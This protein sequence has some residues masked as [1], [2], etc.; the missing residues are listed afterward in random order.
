M[1]LNLLYIRSNYYKIFVASEIEETIKFKNVPEDIQLANVG[2]SHGLL[3]F[4]YNNIPYK[5]FNFALNGQYFLYDY[6][7]LRQYVDRFCENAVLLIPISYFQITRIKLDFQDQRVRYYRFLRKK[8]MDFYSL[9]ERLHYYDLVPVLTA[10]YTFKFIFEDV[11]PSDES[12]VMTESELVKYSIK[13]HESWTTDSEYV[14]DAG[15][16]GFTYNKSLVS[17]IIEC[18]YVHDIRPVL[19]TTP[20]TSVLNSIYNEKTP[21]FFDGFYRFINELQEVYPSLPYFDYSHD[22]RF[23]NDF[24]LFKDGDHLN[25]A[26]AEKF[27]GIVITDLQTSGLLP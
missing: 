25:K 26:G 1:I 24:S 19:L 8:Y 5:G 15:K 6:A 7:I 21:D 22:P 9:Q 13:K 16:E 17:R 2:S 4:D 14:F 12:I 20:V 11:V 10:G 3:S 18:C 27:T 23:E